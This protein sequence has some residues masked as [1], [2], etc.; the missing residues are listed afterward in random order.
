MQDEL[1][2]QIGRCRAYSRVT[3]WS[4]WH[5]YGD[6]TGQLL[7]YELLNAKTGKL[8]TIARVRY[9]SKGKVTSGPGRSESMSQHSLRRGCTEVN[10]T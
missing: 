6:V 5:V 7:V 3:L 2:L 9:T 1:H 8:P 4:R 10:R